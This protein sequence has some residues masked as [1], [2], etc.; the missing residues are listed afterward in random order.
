[1]SYLNLEGLKNKKLKGK[2]AIF[3]FPFQQLLEKDTTN[4]EKFAQD[5]VNESK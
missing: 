2:K 3:K 1:M 5:F 4:I